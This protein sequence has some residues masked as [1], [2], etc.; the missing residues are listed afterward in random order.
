MYVQDFWIPLYKSI[1]RILENLKYRSAGNRRT[2]RSQKILY[3]LVYKKNF[4][5]TIKKKTILV[6]RVK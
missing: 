5:L 4:G 2:P 1:N 6:R 3:K